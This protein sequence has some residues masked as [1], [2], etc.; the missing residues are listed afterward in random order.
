[1]EKKTLNGSQLYEQKYTT[2]RVKTRDVSTSKVFVSWLLGRRRPSR[3]KRPRLLL[4]LLRI[5]ARIIDFC[6]YVDVTMSLYS[7]KKTLS[8]VG[9]AE[10]RLKRIEQVL[11]VKILWKL[12]MNMLLE[13]FARNWGKRD[14]TTCG[15]WQFCL[16]NGELCSF[17]T[18]LCVSMAT[19][20]VC[21][22]TMK[23]HIRFCSVWA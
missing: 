1:M 9:R 16:H 13:N 23:R 5:C 10:S 12:D 4:F 3:S 11:G 2:R 17:G 20:G 6:S 22:I 8:W 19:H 7:I 15:T 14:G 18:F 21:V